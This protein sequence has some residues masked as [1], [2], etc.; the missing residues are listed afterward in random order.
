[1]K[2]QS[3]EK[4]LRAKWQECNILLQPPKEE[5]KDMQVKKVK[6]SE[7]PL[8]SLYSHTSTSL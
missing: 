8:E 7:I 2:T 4:N 1:M 5:Y 6:I 3:G